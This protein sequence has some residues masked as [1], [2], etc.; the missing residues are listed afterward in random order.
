MSDT[1]HE[2]TVYSQ[3]HGQPYTRWAEDYTALM[4]RVREL[5]VQLDERSTD[6]V[7]DEL[8]RQSEEMGLYD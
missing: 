1:I 6:D 8:T 5:E 2:L 3:K 7:L 4:L